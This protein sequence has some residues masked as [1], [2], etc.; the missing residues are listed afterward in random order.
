MIMFDLGARGADCG[1]MRSPFPKVLLL[2]VKP[3]VGLRTLGLVLNCSPSAGLVS[4]ARF[5][6]CRP[7]TPRACATAVSVEKGQE[8]ETA[9][10]PRPARLPEDH[11][12][13]SFYDSLETVLTRYVCSLGRATRQRF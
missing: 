6:R 5:P 11:L 12:L 13:K 7:H 4:P 2:A 9:S 3:W 1:P 10:K 8:T